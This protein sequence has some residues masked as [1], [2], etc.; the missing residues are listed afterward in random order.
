MSMNEHQNL[1]ALSNAIRQHRRELTMNDTR[2][3]VRVLVN[4]RRGIT[5][6]VDP[7]CGWLGVIRNLGLHSDAYAQWQPRIDGNRKFRIARMI[8]QFYGLPIEGMLVDHINGNRLDN[9]LANLRAATR[10][11]SCRNRAGTSASGF[12]GVSWHNQRR[13]WRASITYNGRT[14]SLGLHD[15]PEAAALARDAK[16]LELD[17]TYYRLNFPLD[18]RERGQL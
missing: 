16:A 3:L 7:L 13:K 5:M 11:Q 2:P 14:Y 12:I 6:L 18:L 4:L 8:A 10:A 1:E 15:T 17:L 9:R